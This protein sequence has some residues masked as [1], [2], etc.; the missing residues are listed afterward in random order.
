MAGPEATAYFCIMPDIFAFA[1]YARFVREFYAEKK[2]ENPKYSYEILSRKAGF[3]SRSNLI[4]VSKG[5]KEL[6]NSRIFAVARP[7]I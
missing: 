3:K 2:A 6:T 4:E 5:T 7:S 1:S